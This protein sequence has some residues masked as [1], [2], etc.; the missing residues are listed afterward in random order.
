MAM[1]LTRKIQDS[2]ALRLRGDPTVSSLEG[3]GTRFDVPSFSQEMLSGMG[4]QARETG[5]LGG[6]PA[7][8]LDLDFE[9]EAGTGRTAVTGGVKH[10]DAETLNKRYEHLG[11][12]FD[13]PMTEEGARLLAEEKRA[14][15]IRNSVIRRE[16]GG[17]LQGVA[18]LGVSL[19]NAAYDPL[20]IGAALIPIVGEARQAAWIARFGAVRGR[21]AVGLV[22]GTVGNIL[23]EPAY[24]GMSRALQ[25]DYTMSDA[26]LNVFLGGV[27]GTT[28]G[29]GIGA[30]SRVRAAL[31][32]RGIE[33]PTSETQPGTGLVPAPRRLPPPERAAPDVAPGRAVTRVTADSPE[34]RGQ[35]IETFN[36]IQSTGAKQSFIEAEL[37]RVRGLREKART[38][39]T[40]AKHDKT[41]EV[42]EDL[43]GRV[44]DEQSE[45]LRQ[46]VTPSVEARGA[47]LKSAVAQAA[48]GKQ[49]RTEPIIRAIEDRRGVDSLHKRVKELRRE[50]KRLEKL[51]R[52]AKT[53]E[54]RN[55]HRAAL[56]P[57]QDELRQTNRRLLQRMA[58][59]QRRLQET[60]ER[61]A[62]DESRP[63]RS[64]LY[65]PE[66]VSR[67]NEEVK[68]A[69]IQ[70]AASVKEAQKPIEKT[71]GQ[72]VEKALRDNNFI[73]NNGRIIDTRDSG[74]YLHGSSTKIGSPSP[75][76]FG[77]N[78]YGNGFYTT[79]ALDVAIG[80]TSKG[81]DDKAS[82]SPTVHVVKP[83]REP[84]IL[85]LDKPFTKELKDIFARAFRNTDEQLD[86]LDE[87]ET[88]REFFD[89]VR[90]EMDEPA[91]EIVEGTFDPVN[92]E[93]AKVGYDGLTH[94]GGKGVKKFAPHKVTIFFHE[95]TLRLADREPVF[96]VEALDLD[97]S[98]AERNRDPLA[99][100]ASD[101]DEMAELK[102]LLRSERDMGRLSSENVE[103]IARELRQSDDKVVAMSRA[104][105]FMKTCLRS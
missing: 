47:A 1:R 38:D 29:A 27:L 22:E 99:A 70:E 37:Q 64:P 46:A 41:L 55:K 103:E 21:A 43:H 52:Q 77:R 48:Q 68:Q 104:A 26:L 101:T 71:T 61:T 17:V 87:A 84:V 4:L 12:K 50:E 49:V 53:Q 100:S 73:D 40:R 78:I 97:V 42:L 65:E 74:I 6:V 8:A 95:E 45:V 30:G 34:L 86:F 57:I 10:V 58:D 15:I 18:G 81:L 92:D 59:N 35:F 9:V 72:E 19:L 102:A 82:A 56:K 83:K 39:K 14:E 85:D 89:R 66:Q 24:M 23:T 67:L 75:F 91:D 88:P 93:L 44:L 13:G 16:P 5:I 54:T 69:D 7:G 60:L 63:E 2:R 105:E 51:E 80:Y 20:E 25:R 28:L 62:Q 32:R 79:D 76:V 96:E 90:N 31:R 94:I 36:K 11:L 98:L 3:L 33:V